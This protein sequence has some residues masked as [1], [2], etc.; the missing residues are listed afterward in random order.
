MSDLIPIQPSHPIFDAL[1]E[2]QKPRTRFQLEKFVAGQHDTDE[3]RYKQ[4]LLE[5]QS[6][7]YTIKMASLDIKKAE[8]EIKKLRSSG[9]EIDEIEAQKKELGIEQSKYVFLGAQRELLDLVEM[10]EAFP[11][12]YT[13][14]EIEKNQPDYWNARLLRQ[15][16]LE[17]IGSNGKVVWSSLEALRQIGQFNINEEIKALQEQQKE[18]ENGK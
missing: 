13:Y 10:W 18:I 5:I 9:D 4:V 6:L 14:E 12:K 1:Y 3:Q 17:A 11:H 2:I 8:L 16:Q 15:A 7:I